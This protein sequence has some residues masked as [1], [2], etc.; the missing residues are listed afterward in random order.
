MIIKIHNYNKNE[1]FSLIENSVKSNSKI[2]FSYINQYVLLQIIKNPVLKEYYKRS[3]NI[4]DGI[5]MY[6]YLKILY[7][8]KKNK[9]NRNI[10][11]DIWFDLI[12]YSENKNYSYLFWGGHK[13]N[14]NTGETNIR[15][16]YP[17]LMEIIDGYS[18][19]EKDILTKMNKIK[20]VILF[21]GLGTPNQEIF[22]KEN[23]DEINANVIIP[24]GSAI[25]YFTG[26]RK[27][28][29][30]WMRKIGLEWL[31]RLFQEPRRLWKRYI[32]G[33]PLFIFYVL[34][35]KV[36]LVLSKTKE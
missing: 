5:G 14:S 12:K 11:T 22:I 8:F 29:P 20:P 2:T 36:K 32:L 26:Y 19:N 25:D 3:I 15:R 10:S 7:L 21:I 9:I 24:V 23:L 13:I 1:I 33:I 6:L 30:L 27:R 16:K 31:Y 34:R 17:N 28:A 18:I 4:I 35:Q